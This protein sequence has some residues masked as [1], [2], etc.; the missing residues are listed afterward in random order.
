MVTAN[1][2][3]SAAIWILYL[4]Y[5]YPVFR[6]KIATMQ[7]INLTFPPFSYIAIHVMNRM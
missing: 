5:S 3:H 6:Y 1:D 7:T 2:E 4:T